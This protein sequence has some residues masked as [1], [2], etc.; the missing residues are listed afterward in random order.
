MRSL[1]DGREVTHKIPESES[2]STAKWDGNKLF[3]TLT[4]R[5]PKRTINS[6][7]TFELQIN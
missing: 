1:K 7:Q 6:T 2:K 4:T 5:L 3:L